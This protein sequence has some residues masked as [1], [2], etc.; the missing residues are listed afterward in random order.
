MCPACFSVG[1]YT[2]EAVEAPPSLLTSTGFPSVDA[3][4]G[5]GLREGVILVHGPPGIGKSTLTTQFCGNVKGSRYVSTE[6]SA[7]AVR[8]TAERVCP[9]A[10]VNAFAETDPAAAIGRAR[11]ARLLIVDSL[12]GLGGESDR[13]TLEVLRGLIEISKQ[14]RIPI[15]ALSHENKQGEVL[16]MNSLN[17][18]VNAVI[19]FCGDPTSSARSLVPSKIRGAATI[20][21]GVSLE[22]TSRG[23]IERGAFASALAERGREARAGSVLCAVSTDRGLSLV[24][25]EALA[26]HGSGSLS[27]SGIEQSR[28]KK[29]LATLGAT[30]GLQEILAQRAITI[31]AG[32]GASDPQADLAICAAVLSAV[33]SI[34]IDGGAVLC[35]AVSLGGDVKGDA[36]S[37]KRR[38]ETESAGGLY[39]GAPN[40]SRLAA[41]R[42]VLSIPEIVRQS[43]PDSPADAPGRL[44][45]L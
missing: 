5:G 19:R 15:I 3:M 31:E 41:L 10:T 39:V 37:H 9:G 24:T 14:T 33:M 22:M 16:G 38:A 35:G 26:Q 42:G 18:A 27:T 7:E 28:A 17:H 45:G 43:R 29:L 8:R 1:S 40:V 23:L 36:V 11:G 6:E 44:P 2:K 34:E 25:V 20:G 13:A 12:N 30:F 4:L 32:P 21:A